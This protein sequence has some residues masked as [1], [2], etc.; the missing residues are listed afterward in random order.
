MNDPTHPYNY[1]NKDN[2]EIIKNTIQMGMLNQWTPIQIA[3]EM[4]KQTGLSK[5][6][7]VGIVQT[8]ILDTLKRLG[9]KDD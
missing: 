2:F 3:D 1:I 6:I 4:A 9:E 8:E 7:C 5:E